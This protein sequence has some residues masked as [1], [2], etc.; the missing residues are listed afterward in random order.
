M[1][2]GWE[3][4]KCHNVYAPN[5][6]FCLYCWFQKDSIQP[7]IPI[8]QQETL[9]EQSKVQEI[10][11][12]P[13]EIPIE[14]AP[15]IVESEKS[16][17]HANKNL[18][19]PHITQPIPVLNKSPIYSIPDKY[20]DTKIFLSG[21]GH[22]KERAIN[23]DFKIPYILDSIMDF[24]VQ[25]SK[26][27]RQY[28]DYI[29]NNN[30]EYL[31]DSGAFTYISNPKKSINLEE[32]VARYC[33]YIN[34]FD[35]KNFFELDLDVFLSLEEVE[36][37]RRKIY[38]ETHKKPILVYHE[39]RGREYWTRMCKEYDFISIGVPDAKDNSGLTNEILSDMCDEAHTYGTLV[40][41]LGCAS[42]VMLNSHSMFFDTVDSTSWN[43]SKRGYAAKVNEK[44]E[45]TKIELPFY[46]TTIEAQEED[47]R[48][49]AK[50]ITNYRG[51]PRV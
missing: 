14:E 11:E 41:G 33:Y 48:E 2:N 31:F 32:Y 6:P 26:L 27:V 40:H 51:G 5:I 24:P 18:I 3:C 44:G 30:I 20:P 34:E 43:F 13:I 39:S 28:F 36:N 45:M 17:I 10:K 49:W 46:Y 19:I 42:L 22:A 35:I 9:Q 29:K 23:R 15:K 4:Q 12:E 37:I 7:S 47:L 8:I 25:P 50:F 21:I 1:Q 16:E 38:L